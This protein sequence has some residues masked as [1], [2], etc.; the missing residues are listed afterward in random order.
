MAS[1]AELVELAKKAAAAQAV[2]DH[3][4][5]SHKFVG[6]GSG[7][8]VVYVVDAIVAKGPAF[9]GGMTFIPTGSQSKGLIRAAGLT[10]SNLDERP[11]VDGKLVTLDVAFDGADE[12][13]DDL[14][15]IKGGGACLF[16]EKLV[17]IAAKKFIAVADYRKRSSRLCMKWKSIPI[18]VLPLA[19]PDI[20]ARLQAMGSLNPIVR[21]GLPSKAGECVTDNG[22]WII[23]A[24]FSPLLL[25]GD[26]TEVLDGT[27]RN[28]TGWEVSKLA[29]ELLSLP[30]VVEIGLFYGFNG[31]QA[32]ALGKESRAQK[33]VAAYFGAADGSVD[34][35]T[36]A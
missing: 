11:I 21:A 15:L 29:Q 13:D 19:A 1:A 20:L 18:E 32:V 36:A 14:N 28:H 22:M 34:V 33:P 16:Q 17:A 30:G 9:Y 26:L 24:P 12:V 7:S 31:D 10:L 25:P 4:L 2:N 23:D 3:L 35:Q 5:P 8:T 27:G 6:I